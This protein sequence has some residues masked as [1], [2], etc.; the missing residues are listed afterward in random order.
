MPAT[1]TV[2]F[3]S[4]PGQTITAKLFQ[5]GSDT[6]IA[7]VS[8]TEATNRKGVYLSVFT[9]IPTGLYRLLALVGTTPV[10]TWWIDL[11]LQNGTYQSYEMPISVQVAGV[12]NASPTAG[13]VNGSFGDRLLIGTTN[14]RTVAV[15]G[16]H[17]VAASIHDSEPD[18]IPENAFVTGAISARVIGTNAI[19]ADALSADAVAEIAAAVSTQ[20]EICPEAFLNLDTELL[21]KNVFIHFNSET[22]TYTITLVE[23]TFD[24]LPMRFV[25]NNNNHI[26]VFSQSN[27]VSNTNTAVVTITP[28][29]ILPE[30]CGYWALRRMSDGFVY[31][32][33]PARQRIAAAYNPPPP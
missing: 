6:E 25:L 7:S 27:I 29:G 26:T 23:G 30:E 32:S 13:W 3:F 17:H 14:Q 19:D 9:D 4:P 21:S 11:V 24:G 5:A 1:Q 15:T 28:I 22:R 31:I 2:E 12:Y 10:A 16:S 33:G 18:S 20:V 8:A